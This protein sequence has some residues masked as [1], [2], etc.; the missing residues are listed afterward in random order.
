[1]RT[2]YFAL[3]TV[4]TVLLLTGCGGG[5]GLGNSDALDDVELHIRDDDQPEVILHSPVD[6]DEGASQVL[7][8]GDGEQVDGQNIVEFRQVAASPESGDVLGHNFDQ[9]LPQLSWLPS[10]QETGQDIDSFF[11]DALTAE[12]VTIGSD[13]AIY[14]PADEEGLH[15]Q[16]LAVFRLVDQYPVYAEGEVQEQSGDLPQITNEVGAAPELE[17]HDGSAEAPTEL[18]EE[19]LIEGDGAEIGAEDQL[20]VQYRGWRWS[21]GEIF[22]GSWPE[23]GEAELPANFSLQNVVEGWTEGISGHNVGDRLM[24][25]I[26]PEQAYGGNEGHELEEETLIFVIDVVQAISP[27]DMPEP[28]Q[29]QQPQMPE[30]MSEEELEE[31]MEEMEQ[32]Q[33]GEQAPESEEAPQEESEE[34]GSE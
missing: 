17:D 27:E 31:L 34:S 12:G 32:Q 16:Q 5:E 4:A 33:G 8:A 15:D 19:V 30:D 1:M 25:V 23:E 6:S 11:H 7:E 20:F 2:R 26:P 21:D 18:R 10:L 9:T 14:Y 13:V 28:Q 3:P 22:D 24:L 29:P